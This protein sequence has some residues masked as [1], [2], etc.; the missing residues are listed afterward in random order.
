MIR[1]QKPSWICKQTPTPSI[2]WSLRI[3][4]NTGH[5]SLERSINK[6]N[7]TRCGTWWH[8]HHLPGGKSWCSQSNRRSKVSTQTWHWF[9][10]QQKSIE[11]QIFK[12]T[13]SN[14]GNKWVP[15]IK[16]TYLNHK[17]GLVTFGWTPIYATKQLGCHLTS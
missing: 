2:M 1:I 5:T 6:M 16:Y 7:C 4:V 8:F 15:K 12:L 13:V 11:M 9:P 14:K 17:N 3:K 10:G